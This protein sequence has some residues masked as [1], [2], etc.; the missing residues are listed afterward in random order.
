MTMRKDD[1]KISGTIIGGTFQCV[2]SFTY[3][4]LNRDAGLCTMVLRLVEVN[5]CIRTI[6]SIMTIKSTPFDLWDSVTKMLY[7]DT[8]DKE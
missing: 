8:E 5:P 6:E 4:N 2:R 3:D 7:G 1:V